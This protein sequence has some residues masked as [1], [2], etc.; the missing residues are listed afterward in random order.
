MRHNSPSLLCGTP[1]PRLVSSDV[2]RGMY[3]LFRTLIKPDCIRPAMVMVMSR[4]LTRIP[5]PCLP[6]PPQRAPPSRESS[7]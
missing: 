5:Y 6:A 4:Y 2:S 1:L 3:E 7:R